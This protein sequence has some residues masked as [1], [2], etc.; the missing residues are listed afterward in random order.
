MPDHVGLDLDVVVLV[1][2]GP[3]AALSGATPRWHFKVDQLVIRLR[4]LLL[5]RGWSPKAHSSGRNACM[6]RVNACCSATLARCSQPPPRV[7]ASTRERPVRHIREPHRCGQPGSTTGRRSAGR[8]AGPQA[9]DAVP[10]A[11]VPGPESLPTKSCAAHVV[12]DRSEAPGS[13]SRPR[14]TDPSAGS[15]EPRP[16]GGAAALAPRPL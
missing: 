6:V 10:S 2:R 9:P 11:S 8:R 4:C 5:G 16:W 7:Q 1:R 15:S 13:P 14:P 12:A 3:G